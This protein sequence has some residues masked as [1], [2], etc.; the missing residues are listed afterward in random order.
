MFPIFKITFFNLQFNMS[1]LAKNNNLK[2]VYFKFKLFCR[3]IQADQLCV[4]FTANRYTCIISSL[5]LKFDLLL[6][7]YVLSPLVQVHTVGRSRQ[8]TLVDENLWVL[9][10]TGLKAIMLS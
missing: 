2:L 10:L 8:I 7:W 3:C 1:M 9:L 5:Y 4:L 6:T